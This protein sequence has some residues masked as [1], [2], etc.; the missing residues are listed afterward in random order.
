MGNYEIVQSIAS[1]TFQNERKPYH[2][3]GTGFVF[4]GEE[5]PK[6][7]RILVFAVT[8]ARQIQLITTMDVKGAVFTLKDFHGM[9]LCGVN[10]RVS[11]FIL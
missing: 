10:S 11:L 2:V 9:L 6:K 8:E 4:P 7:G 1:V 3:V 5:E